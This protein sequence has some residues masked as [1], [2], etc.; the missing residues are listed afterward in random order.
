MQKLAEQIAT[1]YGPQVSTICRRMISNPTLAEEAAQESWL[2]IL[3]SLPGFRNESAVSTWIYTVTRRTVLRYVQNEKLYN[4][5]KLG[6]YF[7]SMS[8]KGM[9]EFAEIPDPRR[10]EWI[11]MECDDCLTAILHCLN[12][13][14]RLVLLFR[15][16][17]PLKYDKLSQVF[18]KSEAAVR[19]SFSRSSRKIRNFLNRQCYIF[20]P[21]APCRCKL[22]EPMKY[23]LAREHYDRILEQ[24]RSIMG[25][26]KL[27]DFYKNENLWIK[28]VT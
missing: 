21:Q 24:S 13:E 1:E 26:K 20:N 18:Q 28:N 4:P 5:G 15:I 17:S 8:H 10:R 2:E 11:R 25:I 3:Q 16:F 14:D 19:K 23:S 12:N 7:D 27:E 22:T 6:S 9:Q